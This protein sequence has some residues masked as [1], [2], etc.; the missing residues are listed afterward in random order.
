ME[1]KSDPYWTQKLSEPRQTPFV[2]AHKAPDG[3]STATIVLVGLG[4]VV[5]TLVVL[6]VLFLLAVDD[7]T[8]F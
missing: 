7:L 4:I 3:P 6:F 5:V 2:P 8:A 1:R